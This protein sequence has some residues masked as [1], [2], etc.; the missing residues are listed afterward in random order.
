MRGVAEPAESERE[1]GLVGGH[2]LQEIERQ[3]AVISLGLMQAQLAPQSPEIRGLKMIAE[4]GERAVDPFFCIRLSRHQKRETFTQPR[5]VPLRD[6]RLI[7]VG[8]AAL[9]INGGENGA[10]VIGLHEGAGS[11]INGFA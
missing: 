11:V 7:R 2:A 9:C 3:C 8:V 4:S 5:E 6:I 10:R 1:V